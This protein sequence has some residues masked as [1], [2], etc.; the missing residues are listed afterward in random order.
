METDKRRE[1]GRLWRARNRVA[2]NARRKARRS[3]ELAQMAAWKKANPGRVKAHN[4]NGRLA[5]YGLTPE[6]FE[7]MWESQGRVC[8]ACGGPC[9]GAREPFV[10]HCHENSLVRG[11]LC[12]SCNTALGYVRDDPARLRALIRYLGA[13]E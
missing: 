10:D 3:I 13:K 8:A 11:L 5:R 1:Y 7:A 4:F 2:V 9:S 12:Q 6:T